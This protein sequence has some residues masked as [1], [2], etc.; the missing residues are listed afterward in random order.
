MANKNRKIAEI[1]E[2]GIGTEY[3]KEFKTFG[4]SEH[5]KVL[6]IG[7]GAYPLTEITLVNVTGTKVVGVDKN[8]KA[9]NLANEIIRKKNL[10]EKI[11]IYTGNGL[12]YPVDKFD[13]IIVS[14]CS[15]P[16]EEILENVFKR[17]KKNSAIIVREI[18]YA[19]DYILDYIDHHNDITLVKKMRFNTMFLIPIFWNALYLKKN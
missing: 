18:D 19:I 8:P 6:H 1:Y 4:I 15:I 11:A 16:K 10:D 2:K 17:V 5:N 13:V 9:V 14:S 7:C 12:N 3:E